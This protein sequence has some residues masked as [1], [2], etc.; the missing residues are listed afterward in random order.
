[1]TDHYSTLGVERGASADDIKKA[2]RKM[3]S[4]HHPDKGGDTAKFQA[5]EEAYRTLS[6]DNARSQYDNPQPEWSGHP[7]GHGGFED[8]FRHFGGFGGGFGQSRYHPPRNQTVNIQTTISLEDAFNG[9][10]L[11]ANVT[12]PSGKDQMVNV[13]IP[14]GI[15]HGTTLR[16]AGMGEDNVPG[17]PRGDIHLTVAI[18]RHSQFHREGPD[19]IQEI[20]IP[21]WTAI[22][23]GKVGIKTIDNKELEMTIPAGTQ[24]GTTLSIQNAGMPVMSTPSVRGRLLIKVKLTVPTNLTDT[25]KEFIKQAIQ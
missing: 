24:F 14:V 18:A 8:L 20:E 21:V 12:L 1:M 7:F 10:E 23:G 25:Q 4:Q 2:Y 6:D 17:M 15:E 9:K 16:L 5:V 19:L 13:K 22:L 11:I 3:A